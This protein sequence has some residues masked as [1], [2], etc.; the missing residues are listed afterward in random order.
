M[1]A[2]RCTYGWLPPG[3]KLAIERIDAADVEARAASAGIR[4][5]DGKW[6]PR[7]RLEYLGGRLAARAALQSAGAEDPVIGSH[8]G[9]PVWPAG[10][11]GSISHSAGL[12]VAV[13]ARSR[14]WR[15]LGIDIEA[16][17]PA[18]RERILTKAM[19][20]DEFAVAQASTDPWVWTRA[21]AAK[22]AA[23]KCLSALGAD[24]ALEALVPCWTRIDGGEMHASVGGA[25]IRIELECRIYCG[26]MWVVAS[27]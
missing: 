4:A 24:L 21:W 19:G 25:L 27:A 7:R 23:F 9:A 17:F 12:A 26:L 14:D 11:C 16:R 6:V 18:H 3:V 5:D 20:A 13:A 10:H 22:E 1:T 8:N 2:T 15:S